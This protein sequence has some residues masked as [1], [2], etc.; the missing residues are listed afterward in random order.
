MIAHTWNPD[1]YRQHSSTQASW[2]HELIAKLD[3]SGNERVLDLGCGEG[4]VTAEIA[5]RLSSGSVL[6]LDLSPDMIAFAREH[7]PPERCPNLRFVEGDMLD[8]PFD[9]EF[10]VV[11]SN[12][13]LHWVPDHGR[14]FSGIA[15]ALRPG[16]RVLLQMGGKGNAAPVLA[17]ADAMLEEEPWKDLFDGPVPRYAFYG[18]EEEREWLAE[19]GLTPVRVELIGKD[20]SFDKATDET[21]GARAPQ[22]RGLDG[23]M[24]WIRTT[25]LLYLDRLPEEARPAF[26]A[27]LANRYVERH[28]SPD[29]RIHVP[30]V[31]LEIEAVRPPG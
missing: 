21:S 20:M 31:R 9:G 24:G 25:W 3:L 11:F 16:G 12:A 14:V 4:K 23:L 28:P 10:D 27:E 7:L 22:V 19:A 13:A 8:L 18:P 15:R 6:G 26:V 30:M 2:A 17:L 1:D 5:A 29:G